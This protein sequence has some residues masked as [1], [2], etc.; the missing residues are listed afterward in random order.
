VKEKDHLV[1]ISRD[2]RTTGLLWVGSNK[3]KMGNS[4]RYFEQDNE[5]SVC[6]K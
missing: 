4:S 1:N 3:F 6:I 5:T 2:G